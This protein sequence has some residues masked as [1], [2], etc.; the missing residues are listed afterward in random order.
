MDDRSEDLE[1]QKRIKVEIEKAQHDTIAENKASLQY[2]DAESFSVQKGLSHNPEAYRIGSE[3]ISGACLITIILGTVLDAVL[4]FFVVKSHAG[5]AEM[6]P[7][8]IE[9]F[10]YIV[11]VCLPA[12]ASVFAI[13]EAIIYS[14]KTRKKLSGPLISS[15][16]TIVIFIAYLKIR[17]L[18]IISG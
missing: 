1:K 18:I 14:I 11:L 15:I 7:S 5:L 8:K 2:L 10:V 4:T 12:L 9:E 13:V 6:I 17:E 3:K 16:I